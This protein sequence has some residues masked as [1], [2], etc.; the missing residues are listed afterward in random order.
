MF[1]LIGAAAGAS[2]LLY[3]V[4]KSFYGT[5]YHPGSVSRLA[6]E[7]PSQFDSPELDSDSTENSW[8]MPEN[9]SVFYEVSRS[10]NAN[11][12]HV[13]CLHG[14]PAVAPAK[15]WRV[16]NET[17]L[18]A[19]ASFYTMH[20]RGCGR[21]T[22]PFDAYPTASFWPG[23]K[24]LERC[25]GLGAQIGDIE[26]ARRRIGAESVALLGLSFGGFVATLYAAEFP[27]R[28]SSL[29][30][31]APASM[32]RIPPPKGDLF[33]KV[34]EKLG[35]EEQLSRFDAFKK[36][37][38]NFGTFPSMNEKDASRLHSEFLHHFQQAFPNM[39]Y[40][41]QGR[42]ES[43]GGWAA[44]A[45]F[46]SLG[47]RYDLRAELKRRL[48]RARFNVL[49]VCGKEDLVGEEEYVEY[50]ELFPVGTAKLVSIDGGHFLP[51]EK[52]EELGKLICEVLG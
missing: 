16:C 41:E 48:E 36:Q 8:R 10:T 3:V 7:S 21:S 22:R 42:E 2:I 34:R 43:V 24:D 49:I 40:P 13:L 14:G 20:Q 50:V 12:K 52:P 47:M 4:Y 17:S 46:F 26:R 44:F 30:I 9:I 15:P 45:T 25:L 51:D 32:L 23:C 27:E 35:T 28:V 18:L 29:V 38:F 19:K 11:P 1:I 33:T 31:V 37:Y 6:A 5:T 39:Y